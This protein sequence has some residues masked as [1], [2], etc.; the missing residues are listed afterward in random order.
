[1]STR[2]LILAF[3]VL[4]AAP[5]H[6][7]QNRQPEPPPLP[8]YAAIAISE[9]VPQASN[10]VIDQDTLA[11][12]EAKALQNCQSVPGRPKDCR[13]AMWFNNACGSLYQRIGPDGDLLAYGAVW[14]DTRSMARHRAKEQCKE[15]GYGDCTLAFAI[16][17]PNN[18]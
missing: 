2:L 5:A 9:D 8:S 17:S 11:A 18:G 3:A 10:V 4:L 7:R 16:C 14:A 13:I 15:K 6:A 12:A 1:M